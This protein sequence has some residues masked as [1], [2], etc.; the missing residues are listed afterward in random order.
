MFSTNTFAVAC[1]AALS[2]LALADQPVHCFKSQIA[3]N[4]TFEVSREAV[5]AEL[6]AADSICS[7]ELPN[8]L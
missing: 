8:K 2:K 6:G 4:W 5:K 1:V 3:G 7:H